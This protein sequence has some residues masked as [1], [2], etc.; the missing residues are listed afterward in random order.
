[1][2][3]TT[4]QMKELDDS[5]ALVIDQLTK[6][7]ADLVE[8]RCQT[9]L[10][11]RKQMDVLEIQKKDMQAEYEDRI[12]ENLKTLQAL[13]AKAAKQITIDELENELEETDQKLNEL[14]RIQEKQQKTIEQLN[15]SLQQHQTEVM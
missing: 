15:K 8:E 10:E 13:K 9:E 2:E 4:E 6:E 5:S 7:I 1:M 12:R 14:H 11:L 3:T